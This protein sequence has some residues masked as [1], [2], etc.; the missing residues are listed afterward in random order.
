MAK[1][2]RSTAAWETSWHGTEASPAWETRVDWWLQ[3]ALSVEY[4]NVKT[5]WPCRSLCLFPV[6]WKPPAARAWFQRAGTPTGSL[7]PPFRRGA[8]T[9]IIRQRHHARSQLATSQERRSWACIYS[10]R[11]KIFAS[12]LQITFNHLSYSKNL[13]KY[14]NNYGILKIYIMIKHVITK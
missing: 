2:A 12:L 1:L 3:D 10:L 6:A 4:L 8:R 13:W 14:K 11:P 5:K 7:L 9:N